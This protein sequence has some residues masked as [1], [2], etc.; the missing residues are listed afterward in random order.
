MSTQVGKSDELEVSWFDSAILKNAMLDT[1]KLK[2]DMR[3]SWVVC[4]QGRFFAGQFRDGNAFGKRV[5]ISDGRDVLRVRS[6]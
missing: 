2:K 6:M 4:K 5:E 3:L 1:K